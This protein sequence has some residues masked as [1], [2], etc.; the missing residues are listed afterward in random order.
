MENY[1]DKE[2]FSNEFKE[3]MFGQQID[4]SDICED[5]KL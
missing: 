1:Q 5:Y 3:H 4:E 2:I